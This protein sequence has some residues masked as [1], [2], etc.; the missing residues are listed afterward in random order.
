MVRKTWGN[1]KR[2]DRHED[3]MILWAHFHNEVYL[4]GRAR[5]I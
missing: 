2:I 1:S 5:R 4:P 3:H